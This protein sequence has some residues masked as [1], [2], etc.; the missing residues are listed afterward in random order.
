MCETPAKKRFPSCRISLYSPPSWLNFVSLAF[1][2]L[3]PTL[4]QTFYCDASAGLG[5]S[6]GSGSGF[7]LGCVKKHL[8]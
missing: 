5:C 7:R 2:F 4:W 3:W 1:I 6:L 8:L